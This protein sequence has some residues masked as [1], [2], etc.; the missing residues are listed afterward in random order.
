MSEPATASQTIG[1][2]WHGLD[3]PVWADL[4]RFGAEGQRIYLVGTVT[5]GDGVP[6]SD[7][8]VEIWQASPE[9]SDSFPGFGRCATN[10]EGNF[11]FTTIRP[12]PLPG[13]GNQTQAP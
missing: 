1:P 2:F 6:V 4:T 11:R 5:D 9:M 10:A 7:A 12:G 13:P 3:D 8:C